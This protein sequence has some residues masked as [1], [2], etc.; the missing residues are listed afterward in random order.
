MGARYEYIFRDVDADA[1]SG[2]AA[3]TEWIDL[4]AIN[5]TFGTFELALES[6]SIGATVV[7]LEHSADA[8]RGFT[9]PS[10]MASAS[11]LTGE[12]VIT[13][14]RGEQ[15]AYLRARVTTPAGGPCRVSMTFSFRTA[16]SVTQESAAGGGGSGGGG[17]G[18]GAG[19][20]TP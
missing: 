6:G 4:R 2:E 14:I 9:L 5:A 15:I 10:A 1:L 18:G 12:G 11:T 3:S 13:A 16:D 7:T 19:E 17:S 8:R 20:F